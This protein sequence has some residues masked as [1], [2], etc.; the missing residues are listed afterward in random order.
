MKNK[1]ELLS[2]IS[3]G[4]MKGLI[5]KYALTEKKRGMMPISYKNK[6]YINFFLIWPTGDIVF[7]TG[8]S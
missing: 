4:K 6:T 3:F 7:N 8:T 2:F 1:H 5:L